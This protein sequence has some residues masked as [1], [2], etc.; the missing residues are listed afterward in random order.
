[1]EPKFLLIFATIV[2][3]IMATLVIRD[4]IMAQSGA[5]RTKLLQSLLMIHGYRFVGLSMFIPGITSPNM[6]TDFSIPAALGDYIAAILAIS[7]Y[8][9][10]GRK[11][12]AAMPLVWIFNIWGFVDLLYASYQALI[13]H[14]SPLMGFMFYIFTGYAPLLVVSHIVIFKILFTSRKKST[15][16]N[17]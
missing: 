9:L 4:R 14:I 3:A 17:A 11:S 10:L 13:L 7:S 1:M 2:G 6:P 5:N 8:L 16:E 12:K 15:T